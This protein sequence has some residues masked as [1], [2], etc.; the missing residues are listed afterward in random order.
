M[1]SYR[2]HSRRYFMHRLPVGDVIQARTQLPRARYSCRRTARG[3]CVHAKGSHVKLVSRLR[4]ALVDSSLAEGTWDARKAQLVRKTLAQLQDRWGRMDTAEAGSNPRQDEIQVIAKGIRRLPGALEY[5]FTLMDASSDEDADDME[6]VPRAKMLPQ[7]VKYFDT[8]SIN[9]RSGDGGAGCCAF[10]RMKYVAHGGPS[11][12]NGGHGGSVWVVADEGLNSLISF[13]NKVHWKAW[14]GGGGMGKSQHGAN[15]KDTFIKVPP[16][17][18]VRL[19]G[20]MDDEQPP[21]AELLNHGASAT[22]ERTHRYTSCLHV[23]IPHAV[24]T[25]TVA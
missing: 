16:G 25:F 1:P 23:P 21:V 18:I 11:G 12:G 5:D 8:A 2:F 6:P 10:L 17:T 20:V 19:K 14:P 3:V 13:R 15:G 7:E 4:D 9:V 22:T 24:P